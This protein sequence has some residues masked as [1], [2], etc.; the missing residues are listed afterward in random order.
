[1]V[2]SGIMTDFS[3]L[4]FY[5]CAMVC[6]IFIM[7]INKSNIWKKKISVCFPNLQA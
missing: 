3:G 1:M 4:Y 5:N 7:K 6:F 2:G